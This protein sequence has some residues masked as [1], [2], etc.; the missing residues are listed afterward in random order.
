M[1]ASAFAQKNI[2]EPLGMK[3]TRF[4]DDPDAI[5]RNLGFA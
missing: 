3:N 1:K 4:Y 2:F 5:I